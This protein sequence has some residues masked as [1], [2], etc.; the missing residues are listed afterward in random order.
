VCGLIGNFIS[1]LNDVSACNYRKVFVLPV[2]DRYLGIRHKMVH[3]HDRF[4]VVRKRCK[5]GSVV[6]CTGGNKT[7]LSLD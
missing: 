3:Y 5:V 1:V 7:Q 2:F 6:Q 4:R